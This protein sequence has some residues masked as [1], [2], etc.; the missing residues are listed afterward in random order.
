MIHLAV[1]ERRRPIAVWS[2]GRIGVGADWQAEIEAALGAAKVAVLLVSP[3]FLASRFI[4]EQE[5]PRIM[6]HRK[7]NMQVLPL[8]VRPCAWELE[9]DLAKLQMRP[10]DAQALSL[11]TDSQ[12][13]LDLARFVYELAA[14]VERL[15]RAV[16]TD[17]SS[18]TEEEGS[19]SGV[20]P[21]VN[22]GG[23]ELPNLVQTPPSEA[24]NV[25]QENVLSQF[26]RNW[27]GVWR[28][29][30]DGRVRLIIQEISGL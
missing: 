17:D 20:A 1:L 10:T 27:T 6:Q 12:V 18:G 28:T 2:D 30:A 14:L 8:L 21:P 4:W 16:G 5:M 3:A 7:Q 11:R 25:S 23:E 29:G 13:D 19:P 15:P 24:E 26:H 9:Q 22:V